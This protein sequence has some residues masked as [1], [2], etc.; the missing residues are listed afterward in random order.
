MLQTFF[1]N[2]LCSQACRM[3]KSLE[4]LEFSSKSKKRPG[5]MI[6]SQS[7]SYN[8][9]LVV[10]QQKKWDKKLQKKLKG[11]ELKLKFITNTSTISTSLLA[12]FKETPQ[13][14]K[15]S[16]NEEKLQTAILTLLQQLDTSE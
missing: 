3:V 15:G 16:I 8:I 2:V 4:I 6:I 9:N 5:S 1:Y 12:G 10:I 11:S 14:N 13:C 7:Q